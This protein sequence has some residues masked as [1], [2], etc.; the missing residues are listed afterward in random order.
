MKT[1]ITIVPKDKSPIDVLK[2]LGKKTKSAWIFIDRATLEKLKSIE[3]WRSLN[4]HTR[5]QELHWN[6]TFAHPAFSLIVEDRREQTW[7][8]VLSISHPDIPF[9]KTAGNPKEIF[10]LKM[11]G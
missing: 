3:D 5:L 7:L 2:E 1:P 8:K 11:Q 10:F 4:P 6:S 9:K